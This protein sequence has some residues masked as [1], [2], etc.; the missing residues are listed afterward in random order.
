MMAAP[1]TPSS[2]AMPINAAVRL[3]ALAAIWGAS[4]MLMR[5][6]VPVYGAITTGCLRILLAGVLMVGAM[7]VRGVALPWRAQWR[8]AVIV[9]ALNAAI[10]YTLFA[11][12][13]LALPAGYS[14]ILNATTPMFAALFS[15]I[16]LGDRLT[17]RKGLGLALGFA[18]VALVARVGPMHAG[19]HGVVAVLACLV[20]TICYGLASVVLRRRAAQVPSSQMAVMSQLAAGLLLVPLVPLS[21]PPGA[22]DTHATLALLVL[23]LVCTALALAL[24]FRLIYD[25]GPTKALSVTFLIPL[26]AVAW[27]YALLG[28][29]VTV[30]MVE[31]GLLILAGVACLFMRGR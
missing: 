19:A 13:S 25:L 2:I 1:H 18:G 24:Y 12:A 5:V 4:F 27:A 11:W 26:F 31:G 23:S 14:A 6:I 8:S 29:P 22:I 15:A 9:G 28:E 3:V 16:W 30:D 20:A 10:P 21:P 7:A 17:W